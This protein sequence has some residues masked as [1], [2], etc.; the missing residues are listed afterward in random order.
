MPLRVAPAWGQL[1]LKEHRWPGSPVGLGARGLRV[2]Q[3][4]ACQGQ[5]GRPR[6]D[7]SDSRGGKV[8]VREEETVFQIKLV[9]RIQVSARK[10]QKQSPGSQQ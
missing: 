8:R 9:G 3:P 10:G 7:V 1:E 5:A 6:R 2:C 4:K